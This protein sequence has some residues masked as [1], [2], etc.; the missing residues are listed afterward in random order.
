MLLINKGDGTFRQQ[1]MSEGAS[2]FGTMGVAC[3]DIDNDNNIDIYCAN[4]YS[5]AGSRVIGNVQPGTYPEEI[6]DIIRHFVKGSQL[7]K[8]RG[9]VDGKVK[10]EPMAQNPTSLRGK[11]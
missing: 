8:N 2:D 9:V 3:G 6:M 10:F 11:T 4:M 5:K 1:L 7:W